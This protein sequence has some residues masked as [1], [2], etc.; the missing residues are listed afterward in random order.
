MG[1][2]PVRVPEETYERM[3]RLSGLLGKT[4]GSII[5]EAF[6]TCSSS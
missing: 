3:R 5:E 6:P 2:K 1:S 4:S